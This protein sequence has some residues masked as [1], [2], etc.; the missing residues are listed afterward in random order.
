M[1]K[2]TRTIII[3]GTKHWVRARTEQEYADK[4]LKL[5]GSQNRSEER[6][7]ERVCLSV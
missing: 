6:R 3:N 7:G 5:V 1:A 4:L 2:I